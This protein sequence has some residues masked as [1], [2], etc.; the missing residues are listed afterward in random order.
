MESDWCQIPLRALIL[1]PAPYRITTESSL[2]TLIAS[3][4]EVGL[5]QPITVCRQETGYVVLAGHRRAEACTQLGYDF[6]AARILPAEVSHVE[7]AVV[8][9]ADNCSQRRLNLVEQA[10]AVAVLEKATGDAGGIEALAA[11][12]GMKINTEMIVKLKQVAEMVPA[13]QN[14]LLAGT[15]SLPIALRLAEKDST[16]AV[17]LTD[18][19]S[20]MG[21]G[22]N[23]QRQILAWLE[24]ISAR[25]KITIAAILDRV[26]AYAKEG[27]KNT[28]D[29][30]TWSR[31]VI[32]QIRSIR[33]PA[34]VAAEKKFRE[35]L[36]KLKLPE[37]MRIEHPPHFE[38]NNFKVTLIIRKR[39]DL[40]RLGSY[41][42]RLALMKEAGEI[43]R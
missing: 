25:D 32:E 19:F 36:K 17:L 40:E 23:R 11:R 38:G 1:E 12:A 4:K 41:L 15:I 27:I 34:L 5:L 24:E 29:R 22:L 28:Q 7:R 9:V 31:G 33:Y 8:A 2:E 37:G 16:T 18:L 43:F 21:I 6:I 14:A 3:I 42:Q 13:M 39:D 26:D 10:R 30:G 20:K 35:T